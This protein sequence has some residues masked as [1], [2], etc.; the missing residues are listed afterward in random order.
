MPQQ[1]HA[2]HYRTTI[3]N[4]I[5]HRGT[6][7]T[8]IGILLLLTIA[9]Y[10]FSLGGGFVYDDEQ[11]LVDSHRLVTAG[12][13]LAF[14]SDFWGLPAGAWRSLHYRPVAMLAYSSIYSIFGLSP[15]AFH[16]L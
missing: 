1:D 10:A 6:E 2:W 4:V 15:F 5:S 9:L 16:A 11:L 3:R 12:P 7:S 14:T 8:E 13:R